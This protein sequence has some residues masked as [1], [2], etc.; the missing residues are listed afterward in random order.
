MSVLHWVNGQ[1]G[2]NVGKIIEKELEFGLIPIMQYNLTKYINSK[3]ECE[4][5]P[6]GQ[7]GPTCQ[8]QK[9]EDRMSCDESLNESSND[10]SQTVCHDV[11]NIMLKFEEM[12]IKLDGQIEYLQSAINNIKN[13]F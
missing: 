2:L 1:S 11:Y 9:V 4:I 12:M 3:N 5:F 8:D 6:L 7:I 10:S 13:N